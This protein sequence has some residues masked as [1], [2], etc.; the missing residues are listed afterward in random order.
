MDKNL[1]TLFEF[2]HVLAQMQSK[3]LSSLESSIQRSKIQSSIEMYDMLHDIYTKYDSLYF[4]N[5]YNSQKNA[6]LN[7][8]LASCYTTINE[9]RME[10]EKLLQSLQWK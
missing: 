6:M 2:Q 7:D 1:K 5:V 8:E 9:L 10:N 4:T 3:I